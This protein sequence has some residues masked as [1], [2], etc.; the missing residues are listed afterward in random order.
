MA[1]HAG[2]FDKYLRYLMVSLCFRG[3]AAAAEHRSL[4]D[5]ALARDAEAAVATL[6]RHVVA[7]VEVAL[8][9]KTIDGRAQVL[10]DPDKPFHAAST[11]KVPVMIELFRQVRAG[12]ISLSDPIEVRNEFHSIVDG[13]TF[14]LNDGDDSDSVLYTA[15]GKSLTLEQLNEAMITVSSNLA[16]NIL[17]EKLGVGMRA[18]PAIAAGKAAQVAPVGGGAHEQGRQPGLGEGGAQPDEPMVHHSLLGGVFGASIA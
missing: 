6:T 13:S 14:K 7:C 1:A 4:R 5:A 11:M 12:A 17:I 9:F 3:E 16:T 18:Q 2:A 15:I 10:I 8:A